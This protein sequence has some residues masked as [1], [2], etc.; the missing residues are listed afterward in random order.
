MKKIYY[1]ILNEGRNFISISIENSYKFANYTFHS[2]KYSSFL[3]SIIQ[4]LVDQKKY[5]HYYCK[6][7]LC[8][9]SSR[10]FVKEEINYNDH[11]RVFNYIDKDN[12][13]WIENSNTIFIYEIKSPKIMESFLRTISDEDMIFYTSN[14]GLEKNNKYRLFIENLLSLL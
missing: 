14:D 8:V 4:F 12:C 9:D 11:T 13:Y 6:D 1:A 7:S 2:N 10:K 5:C 3:S